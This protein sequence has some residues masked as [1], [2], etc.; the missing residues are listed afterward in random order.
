MS[1]LLFTSQ[2]DY[3]GK[4][5]TGLSSNL[6]ISITKAVIAYKILSSAFLQ[7]SIDHL[8]E[9]LQIPIFQALTINKYGG[10]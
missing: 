5:G 2:Y 1:T 8:L 3:C 4:N 6:R 10:D 7:F 9:A